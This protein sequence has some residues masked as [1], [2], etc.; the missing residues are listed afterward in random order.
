MPYWYLLLYNQKVDGAFPFFPDM[1]N[2]VEHYGHCAFSLLEIQ[3][4]FGQLVLMAAGRVF[5][6]PQMMSSA[7]KQADAFY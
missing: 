7:S 2:T 1:S 3:M 4:A 5:S 6:V